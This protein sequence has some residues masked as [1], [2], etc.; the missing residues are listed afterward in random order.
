M[1]E[2]VIDTLIRVEDERMMVVKPGKKT[3]IMKEGQERGAERERV[4][5][6]V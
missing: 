6:V 5:R 1:G 3:V 4:K 2:R